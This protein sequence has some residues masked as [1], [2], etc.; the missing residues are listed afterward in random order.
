MTKYLFQGVEYDTYKEALEARGE[1]LAEVEPGQNF[2]VGA[3][4]IETIEK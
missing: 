1:A 3:F 4:E 2:G